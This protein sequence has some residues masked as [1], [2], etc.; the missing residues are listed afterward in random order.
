MGF[1]ATCKDVYSCRGCCVSACERVVR[2]PPGVS[3]RG[4]CGAQR[5]TYRVTTSAPVPP[6]YHPGTASSLHHP[7]QRSV[8][9]RPISTNVCVSWELNRLQETGRELVHPLQIW[10]RTEANN[11]IHW[12]YQLPSGSGVFSVQ[13]S[14]SVARVVRLCEKAGRGVV[15]AWR[16]VVGPC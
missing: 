12:S 8:Y 16:G 2:V 11:N 10:S 3:A 9:Q 13:R 15:F 14:A 6:R 4:A 7:Y 1:T 5:K